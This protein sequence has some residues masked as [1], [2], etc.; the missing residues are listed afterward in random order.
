[1][2]SSQLNNLQ[3]VNP[4]AGNTKEEESGISI[5][6]IV[7]MVISNWY[8]FAISVFLCLVV[9]AFVYKS[10]PKT[11]SAQAT[12][13]VRDEGNKMRYNSKN[14]DNIINSMG[15]ENSGLSLENEI[16]LIKSSPMM[17]NVV[18]ELGL[19]TTCVR[20]DLFHKVSYYKDAPLK[21]YMYNLDVKHD[22]TLTVEVTPLG[23]NRYKYRI[24]QGRHYSEY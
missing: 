20:N 11:Y 21:L 2:E 4:Q 6:D 23:G 1:M 17:L 22:P 10:R 16:Y 18:E 15:I 14:V 12:I 24:P 5:R 13:M 8:W 19:N 7:F 9:S 3:P